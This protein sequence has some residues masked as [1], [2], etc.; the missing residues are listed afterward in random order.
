MY[1]IHCGKEIPKGSSFCIYCGKKQI[2][3]EAFSAEAQDDE[4]KKQ[5]DTQG[6]HQE[7]TPPEQTAAEN[8]T[9]DASA[10]QQEN[11]SVQEIAQKLNHEGN[12]VFDTTEEAQNDTNC[13]FCGADNCQ[14]MYKTTA[15]TKTKNYSWG[16]G[17]C[18]M[19]LLGPFGLLCGFCGAGSKEKTSSEL[20][21]TCMKC[22]K[23]HLAVSDG[24]KK[25]DNF[26]SMLPVSACTPG[27]LFL[28]IHYLGLGI[29]GLILEIGCIF[30]PVVAIYGVLEEISEELG[31]SVIDYLSPGQAKKCLW[32]TLGAM[33][34]VFVIGFL[35]MPILKNILGA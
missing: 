1:C 8:P 4:Q 16:S 34:I 18:G 17:C 27:I 7:T 22:G 30:L 12:T 23:Q 5:L 26:V 29:I 33:A 20:W 19:L 28:I 10:A 25:W 13:P 21:W 14:P 2:V 9:F 6:D 35:G 31:V 32:S 15:E 11:T 3:E 24:L